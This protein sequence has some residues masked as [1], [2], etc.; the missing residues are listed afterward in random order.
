MNSSSLSSR[1]TVS[2]ELDRAERGVSSSLDEDERRSSGAPHDEGY[3]NIVVRVGVV[4]TI[5]SLWDSDTPM[6]RRFR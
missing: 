5:R 6:V 2:T 3:E 4:E 1:T